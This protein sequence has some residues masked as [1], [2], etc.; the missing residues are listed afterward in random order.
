MW[1]QLT[2]LSLVGTDKVSTSLAMSSAYYLIDTGTA[3]VSAMHTRLGKRG[4]GEHDNTLFRDS[5]SVGSAP[6]LCTPPDAY[7][8]SPI[9][10][11]LVHDKAHHILRAAVPEHD[12]PAASICHARSC[13]S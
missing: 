12:G 13:T 3:Y 4:G 2:S 11:V 10:G 5:R 1:I 9:Y 7:L 8:T 6:K